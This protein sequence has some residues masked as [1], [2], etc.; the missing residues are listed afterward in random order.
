MSKDKTTEP[1]VEK[2]YGLSVFIP[3]NHFK[4][5]RKQTNCQ[6]REIFD[7]LV[8]V[9]GKEKTF[10]GDEFLKKLGFDIHTALDKNPKIP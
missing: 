9:G 4:D 8:V 1:I 2:A 5:F 10:T 6:A 3:E 7:V